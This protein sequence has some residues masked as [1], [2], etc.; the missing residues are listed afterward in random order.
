MHTSTFLQPTLS[1]A[2]Y[3]HMARTALMAR[4]MF[5]HCPCFW[6]IPSSKLP[7]SAP[8]VGVTLLQLIVQYIKST[9]RYDQMMH[10]LAQLEESPS[11]QGDSRMPLSVMNACQRLLPIPEALISVLK[12]NATHYIKNGLIK[13]PITEILEGGTPK[14]YAMDSSEAFISLSV[15]RGRIHESLLA[16]G[17]LPSLPTLGQAC[18][19][20]WW[21][22]DGAVPVEPL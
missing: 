3:I 19:S 1:P 22:K 21:E 2:E 13:D 4:I 11:E 9:E 17:H 16:F 12:I 15:E 8:R 18:R 5:R 10:H 7:A 6:L 14:I 20:E